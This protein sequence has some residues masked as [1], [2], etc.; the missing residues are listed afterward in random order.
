VL[1]S[2]LVSS[3]VSS[4]LSLANAISA[5]LIYRLVKWVFIAAIG[6]IVFFVLFRDQNQIDPVPW[7]RRRRR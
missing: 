6:W 7:S 2:V 1:E 3:L 4:G 5:T